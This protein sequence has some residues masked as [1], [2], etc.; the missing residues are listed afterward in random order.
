MARF[1]FTMFL[2]SLLFYQVKAQELDQGPRNKKVTLI[3]RETPLKDVFKI[4]EKQ[5]GLRFTYSNNDVNKHE[6]VTKSLADVTVDKLLKQIFAGRPL[7]WL[8][9]GNVVRIGKKIPDPV[10]LIITSNTP[11]AKNADSVIT[12]RSSGIVTD[13][14]WNPIRGATVALK[15]Q[16]KWQA[17]DSTG[18][19]SFDNLPPG[20][21]LVISSIGYESKELRVRAGQKEIPIT[22]DSS[23]LNIKGVEIFPTAFPT[24]Y[25]IVAKER[26]TG[27]F[28][29]IDNRQLNEQ[30]GMDFTRRIPSLASGLS[31]T[32]SYLKVSGTG[33]K[34][35]GI[36]TVSGPSE[37]L[38]V[39]DNFPYNGNLQSI[40]PYDIESITLLKDAVAASI[41]GVRAG[42][43]VLVVTTKKSKY[44]QKLRVSF[45]SSVTISEKPDLFSMKTMRSADIIAVEKEL[46]AQGFYDFKLPHPAHFSI[47]PVVNAL[48]QAKK[49]DISQS[50]LKALLDKLS[51][52][53]V[54]NDY[55]K[56]LYR[57]QINSQYAINISKGSPNNSW[58][59]SGGF[60]NNQDSLGAKQKRYT[61]RL[62][63]A[64]KLTER[65]EFT[66]N[67]FYMRSKWKNGATGIED[68]RESQLLPYVSLKDE[69]GNSASLPTY[70]SSL[71]AQYLDTAGGK[72]LLDWKYYPLEDYKYRLV[73]TDIQDINAE[74][75]VDYKFTEALSFS[76]KYHYQGQR[77]ENSEDQQLE[78]YYTRDLINRFSQ[79]NYTNNT[80]KYIV[81]KGGILDLRTNKLGGH[82][83]RGQLNFDKK[84]GR[85]S[86]VA[87]AGW[88]V[89]EIAKE[90]KTS[91][92]YGYNEDINS[93][94]SVDL[95]NAYPNFVTG[96]FEKIPDKMIWNKTNVRYVSA[97][98]NA[99]YTLDRKY[100]I[101]LSA[102]RDATN[103]LGINIKNDWKPLWSAGMSWLVSGESF[104]KSSFLDD[105][106][107]RVTYGKSGN[108]DPEKISEATII[109]M[110]QNGALGTPYYRIDNPYDPELR[111]EQVAMLNAAIDFNI[112]GGLFYGTIEVYHKRMKDLYGLS[113]VDPTAGLGRS[114]IIKN[115]G[116][117]KGTGADID[118]NAIVKARK[119]IWRP[120]LILSLYK[121]KVLRFY[122]EDMLDPQAITGGTTV[123]RKGYPVVS[124]FAYP[125]GGLDPATGDPRGYLD[126]NLSKD[127]MK[128]FNDTKLHALEYVG[129]MYPELSGSFGN[130][131]SWNNITLTA[132]IT[133]QLG[134]YFRR[135]SIEY[136]GLFYELKGHADYYKRWQKP[137]DEQHTTVPSLQYPVANG[138]DM[139]YTLSRMPATKGDHVKLQYVNLSY[140]LNKIKLGNASCRSIQFYMV[141]SNPGIIWKANK[142]NIDPDN[143][144]MKAS[145]S[146]AFGANITLEKP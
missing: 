86:I 79:V 56:Y 122:D 107:L 22:L 24:G 53:D 34:V 20:T 89:S 69:N 39:L 94:V 72:K 136:D 60:D 67:L 126:G 141:L 57:N 68:Y 26:A 9:I 59:I 30:T 124:Y 3:V 111:W 112:K 120:N 87:I 143:Q 10:P 85:H 62:A 40:N 52:T 45:S 12:I 31:S 116:S 4:I 35:R 93:S 8:Y 108:V 41:W 142:D 97:Y 5:T 96:I 139:L 23:V 129:P 73:T 101:S 2:L 50:E 1:Y 51:H 21:I 61:V 28:T 115:V 103:S 7:G 38:I 91:R 44:G 32:P 99:S 119:F 15:G 37:P 135:K 66:T 106:K 54:R 77:I 127:Y 36:S 88:Q 104:Y 145:A 84:F 90:D 98:T 134:Y 6:L 75:G 48:W 140:D 27:S 114:M 63:H 137:G 117:M 65:L 17:T 123:G 121:D 133:Y 144:L 131:F 125:Y 76:F 64:I 138:R 74:F 43:G 100:I 95:A 70:S 29:K 25:E 18:R 46:F 128:I 110:G 92:T 58:F 14:R 105:L 42:N 146:I 118:L 113:K 82:D 81:P 55:G 80:I 11:G 102:R 78:S 130:S 109:N 16:S 71:R 83:F 132:R 49:G 19:Y 33:L 47:T 13:A